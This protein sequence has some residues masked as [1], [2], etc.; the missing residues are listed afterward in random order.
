MRRR[1]STRVL[2]PADD[3]SADPMRPDASGRIFCW[4]QS[5][6]G[7]VGIAG[8]GAASDVVTVALVVEGFD[9]GRINGVRIDGAGPGGTKTRRKKG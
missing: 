7:L 1:V 6:S 9:R 2:C 5:S 8:F 4:R 3:D